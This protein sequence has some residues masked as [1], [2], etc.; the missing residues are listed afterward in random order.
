MW[1]GS[2][3]TGGPLFQAPGPEGLRLPACPKR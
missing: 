1:S 3:G 2:N